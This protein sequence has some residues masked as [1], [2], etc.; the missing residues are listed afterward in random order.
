L[1]GSDAAV[2]RSYNDLTG[3]FVNRSG[4]ALCQAAAVDENQGRCV[5]PHNFEQ[6]RMNNG[7]SRKC[8]SA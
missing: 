5:G 4:D 8:R 2:V 3:Q 1:R 7:G 6:L